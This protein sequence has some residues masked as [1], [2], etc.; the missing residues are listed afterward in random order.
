[1]GAKVFQLEPEP[2]FWFGSGSEKKIWTGAGEKWL[3]STTLVSLVEQN[4]FKS[5][6]WLICENTKPATHFVQQVTAEEKFP[7][8]LKDVQKN[9]VSYPAH[10]VVVL[11]RYP[12]FVNK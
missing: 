6:L 11:Y 9:Q 5:R 3:G 1:M 7:R 4:P 8:L 10:I 12:L 2:M